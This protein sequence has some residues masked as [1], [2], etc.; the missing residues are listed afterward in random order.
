MRQIATL[1]DEAARQFTDYL[2]TLKIET[3]LQPEG[4]AR[5]VWVCDEDLVP[6][7]R[8]ELEVFLRDPSNAR[9]RRSFS[10]A[11]VLREEEEQREE[12]FVEQQESF[13]EQMEAAGA[14][15]P[16]PI[17]LAV[18]AISILVAVTTNLG[19]KE[20]LTNT[21][22]ITSN[23][24]EWPRLEEVAAGKV[25][26][27]VTPIFLHFSLMH[28]VFNLLMFLALA[29]QVES[30]RGSGR[31]LFLVLVI[32]VASNLTEYYLGLTTFEGLRPIFRGAWNFGGLSGVV[33]GL[34]GYVWV[35]SRL[36]P[37]LG[38]RMPTEMVVLLLGWFFLCLFF[39][40]NVANG[41]H[42]GGLVA[43]VL[44]GAL[45]WLWRSEETT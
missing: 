44:L 15:G 11:R 19:K 2:L 24:D 13:K 8:Q 39:M 45:P 28:L 5:A 43:G 14:P 37:D 25:W 38:L 40:K 31:L 20:E 33:Y 12:E 29:G 35:K 36:E 10:F 7:A 1:P 27:L 21:L 6:Q 17:T 26:R 16:R 18:I 34:F 22:Y 30:L 9:Y 3:Q 32:A 41:A 23:R 42:A 4:D